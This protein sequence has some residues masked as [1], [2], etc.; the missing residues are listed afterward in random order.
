MPLIT[1]ESGQLSDVTKQELI[2]ELTEVAS[3]ITKIPS[4]SF[5][6]SIHELPDENIAIGGKTVAEL[7]KEAGKL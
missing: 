3:R 5:F 1:F 6:V 7:K 4:T 2:K